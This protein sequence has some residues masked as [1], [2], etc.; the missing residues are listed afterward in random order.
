MDPLSFSDLLSANR[1]YAR[2]APRPFDGIAHAG[3]AVVTC[4]DSRLEPLEMI[5]LTLGD[6]K[7]L[8]TPGG[9]VTPDA[10]TG[11]VLAAHLLNVNRILVVQHT[12]C[13]MASGEDDAI[14][15]RV[16]DT[17]GTDLGPLPIGADP[18]QHGRIRSDV[19]L[20]QQH[21]L[22]ADRVTVAGFLYDVETSLLEQIA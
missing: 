4:M 7:I 17:T 16:L 14:R 18:D 22:I 20:L 12:H 6:A 13:A 9:H 10:L 3:V 19:H 8:R 2:S 1:R 11:C 15:Q 5:G 21:P